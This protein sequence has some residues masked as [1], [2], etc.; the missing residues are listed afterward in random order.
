MI[1]PIPPSEKRFRHLP[2]FTARI[3]R[4]CAIALLSRPSAA[5]RTILDRSHNLIET[6]LLFAFFFRIFFSESVNMISAAT[7]MPAYFH[8]LIFV[9]I[10]AKNITQCIYYS[11][12]HTR[13][14]QGIS[15]ANNTKEYSRVS[16]LK[17]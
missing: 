6:A 3:F 16:E 2:T 14:R 5:N 11:G 13:A 17:M 10:E 9:E 7:L 1:D 8:Y 15:V 12:H 4:R